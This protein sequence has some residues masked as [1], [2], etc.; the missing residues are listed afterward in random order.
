VQ[1]IVGD[2]V[3]IEFVEFWKVRMLD[4]SFIG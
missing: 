1:E 2:F 4:V 3:K